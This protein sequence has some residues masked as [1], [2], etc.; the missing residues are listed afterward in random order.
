MAATLRV[1]G[2]IAQLPQNTQNASSSNSRQYEQHYRTFKEQ[3][4]KLKLRGPIKTL[5]L[6]DGDGGAGTK[7]LSS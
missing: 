6:I 2:D 4:H 7:G 5:E 3:N 1:Q